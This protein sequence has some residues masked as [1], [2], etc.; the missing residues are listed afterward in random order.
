MW[1]DQA[2]LLNLVL[3]TAGIVVHPSAGHFTGTLVN[4]LLHH[5]RLPAVEV[6]LGKAPDTSGND[7]KGK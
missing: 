7:G 3:Q 2:K 4:A 5:L 6:A 1:M